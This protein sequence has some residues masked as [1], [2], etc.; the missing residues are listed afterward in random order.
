MKLKTRL[1]LDLALLVLYLVAMNTAATGIPIHEWLSV[2]VAILV[3]IHLASEWDWTIH[4]VT[5]F[6][7][8]LSALSRVDLIL[9][10]LLFVSFVLVMLSGFMVSQSIFPLLGLTTA[11]GPTWKI[12]HSLSADLT[13][14]IVGLH[15]GL[16]WRWFVSAF[17]RAF[18]AS[19]PASAEPAPASAE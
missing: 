10:V 17:K 8:R 5:R 11:V 12:I 19:A 6:F 9:D 3:L 14:V 18:R 1:L 2:G 13:L 15:A 7:R 4:A 16:H